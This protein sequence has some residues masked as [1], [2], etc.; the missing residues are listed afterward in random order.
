MHS[1]QPLAFLMSQRAPFR[2]HSTVLGSGG[3][4]SVGQR[5]RL[6]SG[7]TACA[8][9]EVRTLVLAS[10]HVLH[11]GAHVIAM[12]V[13]MVVQLLVIRPER[14]CM[15][16][17]GLLPCSSLRHAEGDIRT[18][19]LSASSPSRGR[20]VPGAH[21]AA[22]CA[23]HTLF[24]GSFSLVGV[25]G[26]AYFGVGRTKLRLLGGAA[27]LAS[28]RA[29][30]SRHCDRQVAPRVCNLVLGRL[31]QQTWG[32]GG[33]ACLL[34]TTRLACGFRFGHLPWGLCGDEHSQWALSRMAQ[35]RVFLIWS[36]SGLS[37]TCLP[38]G[39]AIFVGV[40]VGV[41]EG[42]GGGGVLS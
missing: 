3:N 38:M 30:T 20:T 28:A 23:H 6:F 1:A 35:G 34:A 19:A 27:Q 33:G 37:H 42:G 4:A 40:G 29:K 21:A 10:L 2:S 17:I 25:P 8:A 14:A 13:V 16:D 36:N 32:G 5:C 26:G 9:P 15:R 41:C 18:V 12:S 11:N 22:L 39:V 31:S 7:S 24:G